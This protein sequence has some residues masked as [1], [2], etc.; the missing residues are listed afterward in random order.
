M[1]ELDI[2]QAVDAARFARERLG[3]TPDSKQEELLRLEAPRCLV[4][5]TRQWGKSTVTAVMA[6]HRAVH[7]PESLTLVVSPSARQ[8]RLF[9]RKVVGFAQCLG[10]E[11]KRDG[12]N[13]ISLALGNG[14][15]I[16]GV[17]SNEDTVRGFSAVSLLVVDEAARVS[18]EM[19]DAVLPMVAV[20]EGDVWL[21]STPNGKHGF[22]WELWSRGGARWT[23]VCLQHRRRN[24]RT[25]R[26][27]HAEA[28][29]TRGERMYR[30]EFCLLV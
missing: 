25:L 16:V 9:L 22:F 30:Q 4:N 21:L 2:R 13:A 6:L 20:S 19:W 14:S 28:R 17:P 3:F 23:R 15:R 26:R 12:D 18:D 1:T 24:P 7:R 11:K 5:C 27:R 8:S 29:R 10:I